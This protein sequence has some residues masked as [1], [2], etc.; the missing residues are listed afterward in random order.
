M[1]PIICD[2]C[3]QPASSEHTARRLQRL[4]WSTRYRPIHMHTLLLGAV[5]PAND[6]GFLYSPGERHDGEAANIF[7][8][9]GLE[10]AGKSTE[11]L[12]AELHRSGLFLT[13]VLECPLEGVS[14]GKNTG[15]GLGA[16]P[17]EL[18]A[19][20]LPILFTR[21]RR[22]LKPKRVALISE[23]SNPLM[24]NF[25]SAQLDCEL[26]LDDGQ[27]FALDHPDPATAKRSLRKLRQLL[28]V[29]IAR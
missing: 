27:P 8:A 12:H 17:I 22:S 7:A 23:A 10:T 9:A 15:G 26:L 24:T 29:P 6:S 19:A 11:T 18:L 28:A 4:E 13:H 25:T 20:R 1:P 3:G 2:G 21:I 5:S 16:F 14:A